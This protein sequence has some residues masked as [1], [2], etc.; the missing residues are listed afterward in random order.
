MTYLHAI[1]LGIV[2][3]LGEFLP[4]S[5]SAHLILVPYFFHWTDNNDLFDVALHWGTLIALFAFFWKDFWMLLKSG[6]TGGIRS[7][8]GKLFWMIILASIPAGI[9][10]FLF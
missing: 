10:G 7:K 8:E 6:I 1:V 5:S 3:G 2:Q 4:I 9:I